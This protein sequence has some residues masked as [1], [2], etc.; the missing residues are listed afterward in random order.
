MLTTQRNR[1]F[2][3]FFQCPGVNRESVRE[4]GVVV[5]VGFAR[6]EEAMSLQM[7]ETSN[8]EIARNT[9]SPFGFR[10]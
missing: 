5:R 4:L 6:K 2:R 10:P 9:H 3:R 1:F 8:A 7:V